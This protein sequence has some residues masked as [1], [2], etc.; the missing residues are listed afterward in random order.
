MSIYDNRQTKLHPSN[1]G[2]PYQQN[3]E[4]PYRN[5]N[6]GFIFWNYNMEFLFNN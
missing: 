1:I 3:M 6:R 4:D 5:K 2:N